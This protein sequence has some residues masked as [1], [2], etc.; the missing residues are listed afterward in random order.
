VEDVKKLIQNQADRRG[1]VR[2][3]AGFPMEV[4]PVSGVGEVM[5]PLEAKCRDVSTGGICFETAEPVP[6]SYVYTTFAGVRATAGWA[7]LTKL[8]R[9]RPDS[10]AHVAGGRFRT[11]L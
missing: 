5:P 8:V 1:A 2:V 10:S 3:P 11:D 6:T 7:I 4:Y 9:N